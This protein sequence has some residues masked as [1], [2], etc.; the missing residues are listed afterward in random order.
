MQGFVRKIEDAMVIDLAYSFEQDPDR[1]EDRT[2]CIGA[3]AYGDQ[4]GAVCGKSKKYKKVIFRLCTCSLPKKHLDTM[5]LLCYL[6][7]M[8]MSV[9][10]RT[11]RI[12]A[13]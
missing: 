13:C 1:R 12:Q 8:A 9:V 4:N 2:D 5:I 6:F 3:E 10:Q 7:T 11:P